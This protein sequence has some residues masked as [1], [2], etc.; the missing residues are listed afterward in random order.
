MVVSRSP[1]AVGRTRWGGGTA[2][3]QRST[4]NLSHPRHA[5]LQARAHGIRR[6][7]NGP[8]MSRQHPLEAIV[9]QALHRLDLLRPRVPAR[10]AE[11]VEVSAGGAPGQMVAGEEER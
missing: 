4:A 8:S 6:Q 11:G 10:A 3:G 1:L 5:S 9:E 7:V 2:N